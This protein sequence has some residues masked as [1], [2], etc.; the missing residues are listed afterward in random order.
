[1]QYLPVLR[2]QGGAERLSAHHQRLAELL[3]DKSDGGPF[4]K[5]PAVEG[6]HIAAARDQHAVGRRHLLDDAPHRV[7]RRE[8]GA[9]AL[10]GPAHA[11]QVSAPFRGRPRKFNGWYGRVP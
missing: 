2:Q 3:G 8:R 6:V 9:V 4:V 10:R 1:M 7:G 5:Q 11:L